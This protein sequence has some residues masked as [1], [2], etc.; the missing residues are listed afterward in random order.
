[1]KFLQ[2]F[3]SEKKKTTPSQQFS[4]TREQ[5][6]SMPHLHFAL[7]KKKKG[8]FGAKI[9]PGLSILGRHRLPFSPNHSFALCLPA[10]G[11]GEAQ[12]A[13][14]QLLLVPAPRAD[15][16]CGSRALPFSPE[17]AGAVVRSG[18]LNGRGSP[19]SPPPAR[20][21]ASRATESPEPPT[22]Y[23]GPCWFLFSSAVSP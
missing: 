5:S 21:N 7:K 16:G 14:S 3:D 6:G 4:R 1:M 20:N 12:G 9:S 10:P 8:S 11:D 19:T 23:P 18:A 17:P 13:S 2:S 22:S 15:A